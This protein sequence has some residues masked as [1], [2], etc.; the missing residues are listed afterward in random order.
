MFPG[1]NASSVPR[2][3]RA[4]YEAAMARL[5]ADANGAVA[6]L[7]VFLETYPSSPLADDAAEQL[8]Q[9]ALAAGRTD[10]GMRW[11]GWILARRPESD[12]AAPAR[13]KLAQLEYARDRRGAARG[14]I[15]PLELDRLSLDDQRAALRLRIA[16]AESAME[17][18]EQLS[19]LR[20]VLVAESREAVADLAVQ[21]RLAL[22]LEAVDRDIAELIARVT[23]ADL[24]QMVARL[25]GRSPAAGVALELGRRALDAGR[26]EL[27]EQR[28]EAAAAFGRSERDRVELRR[29]QARLMLLAEIAEA[30]AELPPLRA[31]LGRPSPRTD[32]ARGTIGVVLPLSG[33]FAWYGQQSLRGILLATDLFAGSRPS[34]SGAGKPDAFAQG[35]RRPPTL[36]PSDLRLVVR[37]SAGDP[38]AAAEAVRELARDPSLVAVV[39]PIFS[40]ESRAAA[41]A[42]DALGVPLIALSTREDLAEDRPQAFRTR[43]TP[44][45]EVGVLVNHAFDALD[46]ERFAVLYPRNRYGRGMRK[47][48]WEA[49]T[50]RGGKMVAVSSYDPEDVDF[51]A[52]IRGMIGYRFL[53]DRERAALEERSA[54]LRSARRL[55]PEDAALL[56]EA[57][58]AVM[59]PEQAPLPP[60]VDFDVLF[61]PDAA[62]KIALIAPGLAFHEIRD[63]GLLGSS[64]WLDDELLRVGRQ[65][66]SGAVISAP[67]H[68]ESDLRFVSE[69]VEG[70]RQ[71]FG[72]DPETYAA[73]AF[74]AT[75]LLL[76]Q[77]SAGRSD[78]AAVRQGL[79][80]TRAYPGASGVLTMHPSGNARRRPLLLRVSGRRFRPVD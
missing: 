31:L 50:A 14:W 3:Q 40:Q 32:G 12:R 39:G 20:A 75:N 77:L 36:R 79:L 22:R 78:R 28:L 68:L 63:V 47:L 17:R 56:R 48:Y 80:E 24:E 5:P 6:S 66:V 52:A 65:H 62:E 8:S 4:A 13:L 53:T 41:D 42:A 18:L 73:E 57:A 55:E 44:V 38:V 2:E 9:L 59:G 72:V 33:D 49:V 76:V 58:Y 67:F 69:F 74:D 26:L 46:A 25:R 45:D 35:I 71:T 51:S 30:E 27:A 61:V 43:T 64:D 60:I 1:L 70:Y 29:L 7:E 19:S 11:L 37:D 16:L 21:D 23:E 34:R 54:L 15:M 10:E